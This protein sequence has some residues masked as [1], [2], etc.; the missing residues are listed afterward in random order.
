[1]IGVLRAPRLVVAGWLVV[2]AV[3]AAALPTLEEAQTGSLGDLVPVDAEAIEAEQRSAELF[4]FPFSSR[5]LVVERAPEGLSAEQ[6][7]RTARRVAEVNR[8]AL[9]ALRDAAGAYG[10]TNAVPGLPFARERGTTTLTGLL[11]GLDIGQA[12]RT[13][14]AENFVAALGE[15]P[16][17]TFVGVTGAVPARAAQADAIADR[18]PLFE[19]VT[20]LFIALTVGLYLRSAV[21]PL[22]TL[23]T[24]AVAY[25]VSVRVVALLGAAIGVSV[26]AEVEPV[27]VALLFGVVTD[28]A[29]F[30]M[31]RFRPL[32]AAGMPG[33]EAARRTAAELTPI[34]LTCGVAVAAGS[35]ALVVADLG[36]LKAFGPGM[37]MSVLIGLAVVLTLLP[38]LMAL[39]GGRLF[40][41]S[42][43]ERG[44]REARGRGWAVRLIR[45]AVARPK[46]TIA[47]SLAI[48]A[49]MGSG[50]A[51]LE[52]GNPVIRGLPAASEPRQAY[53]QLSR[54]FAPGVAAPTTLIVEGDGI[55]GKRDELAGL[56]AVLAAQPGIAG[57]LGPATQP[58]QQALGVVLSRTG[59]AARFV[60]I[61]AT[62]PLGATAIRRQANLRV[63]IDDLTE[64]VGLPGAKASFAG[65]TALVAETIEEANE[66]VLT[67]LPA[68]LLAVA[69]VLA[70]FLRAL[71]APL[72]LVLLAALAPV[73]ALGLAVGLFQGVLG[74][75]ELTYFVP[76]VAA[77]LLVS[78][79]SDYN[80]FVAG[81]IWAE[82]RRRPLEEAI[83]TG[84]GDAA[85]AIAAAGIVL[86]A[87]FAGLA[88]VPIDA[89]QQLAFVLSAGL[90]IDAFLIRLVLAPAVL[91]L[92]ER[93]RQR[94]R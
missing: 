73:A 34:V 26:P 66:D 81:S 25:V 82:L 7:A 5:T 63:R 74:Q 30:F 51:W 79:G 61:A 69:L 77:V 29:L 94:M 13:A 90:L 60:L 47:V 88:V 68:V 27:V 67:V 24:V 46:A 19:L 15:P 40:W 71:V 33:D 83:V 39:L 87:S 57:V 16:P 55:T 22:V 84:G 92:V 42:H 28:Y 1:L 11:F 18:L 32:V 14:R 65:D 85:H 62:D 86:A 91:L 9:P 44:P 2:A 36:F 80:V 50:L 72:V 93:R 35:A 38:A 56:Q 76:I 21:A 4:L 45:L 59:D 31:S 43:P 89:F 48:I 6:I 78:L 10:I 58:S 49:A 75:G 17:G 64:A 3:L 23:V 41:P 70:V 12:G 53:E 8:D 37:A 52:L 54:G 20:V